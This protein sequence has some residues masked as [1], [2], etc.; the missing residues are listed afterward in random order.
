M[1]YRGIGMEDRDR[2]L[3]YI[4]TAAY[5]ALGDLS[6]QLDYEKHHG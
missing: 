2:V 1:S 5:S 4:Y 3:K 6:V